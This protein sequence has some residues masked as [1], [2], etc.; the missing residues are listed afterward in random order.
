MNTPENKDII[1]ISKDVNDHDNSNNY[2]TLDVPVNESGNAD[3]SDISVTNSDSADNSDS[4]VTDSDNADNSDSNDPEEFIKSEKKVI[5]E[6]NL[7][8]KFDEDF[9]IFE[10][11]EKHSKKRTSLKKSKLPLVIMIVIITVCI[12]TMIVLAVIFSSIEEAEVEDPRLLGSWQRED[13]EIMKI[14]GDGKLT[15]NGES[16]EYVLRPDEVIEMTIDNEKLRAVYVIDEPLL[17]IMIPYHGQT[18]TLEYIRET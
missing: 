7:P 10:Y 14:T 12:I 11:V 13:G 3:N 8:R 9:D 4:S 18:V 16:V 5:P 2:D 17:F 6:Y 1:K 15:I